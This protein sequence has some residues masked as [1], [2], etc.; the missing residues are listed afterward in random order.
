MLS[1][2]CPQLYTSHSQTVSPALHFSLPDH[3]PSFTLL[4]PRPCP[5]LYS[6]RSQTVSPAL[7][8]SLPD[9]VP[10]FTLLAPRPCPQLYSSHSQT[11][12]SPSHSQTTTCSFILQAIRLGHVRPV[13]RGMVGLQTVMSGGAWVQDQSGAP[14]T[15][16]L[17][18]PS[19]SKLP[20]LW[21]LIKKEV[22]LV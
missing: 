21:S 2:S 4:T 18:S 9:H 7:L 11:S 1:V 5:Q 15:I 20:A 16:M 14:A 3:V 8:F 13:R 6:S 22:V 12:M 19:T 17:E 10:S